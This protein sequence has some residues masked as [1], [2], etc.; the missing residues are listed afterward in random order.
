MSK[1]DQAYL[2]LNENSDIL[3]ITGYADRWSTRPGEPVTFHISTNRAEYRADIVELLGGMT[4]P[5]STDL[6]VREVGADCDGVHPGTVQHTDTGS[7]ATLP[8][9]EHWLAGGAFTVQLRFLPT[10][11]QAT[12]E[13]VLFH[14]GESGDGDG[15][16]HSVKLA[17]DTDGRLTL[18]L[19]GALGEVRLVSDVELRSGCWFFVSADHDGSTGRARLYVAQ[20]SGWQRRAQRDIAEASPAPD[21]T[22]VRAARTYL[23]AAPTL[24]D[25]R[26]YLDS[27]FNGKIENPRCYG[28]ALDLTEVEA[29]G[30]GGKVR[31]TSLVA[32]YDLGQDFSSGRLHDLSGNNLHGTLH[33]APQRGVTSSGW[34]GRHTDFHSAPAHYAA[35][36]FHEDDIEDS[37]WEPSLT[38]TV[39]AGTP[40]GA[41]ALRLRA[42]EE[43]DYVPFFVRRPENSR[44]KV[45]FLVPSFTYQAYAN[46]RL[47]ESGLQEDFMVHDMALAPQ[48]EFI[49]RHDEVGKS[50]YDTHTDGSGVAYSSRLRPVLNLRP[51]YH[52]WLS[53]H[54]RHLAADLFILGW[55][56]SLGEDYDF[57]IALDEDLHREGPALLARYDTLVTGSHP[58]YWTRDMMD[59]LTAY[60]GDGGRLMY[61]G[62]NGFYWV[63]S[64]FEDRPHLIE[65]RRGNSGTRC[66]DSPPGELVHSA[67]G[68]HGGL[69]RFNG[70]VP[71]QL[72]GVGM[73]A[74]GWGEAAGYR[75][76]DDSHDE[77][78]AFIFDGIA[79]DEVIGDFGYVLG[80]AAGDEVDRFG[81]DL[82]TPSNALRLATSTGLDDRYQI[83]QEELLMTAPGQGGTE[84]ELVRSDLTYFE[85][86]G[87]GAVFSTGS[88]CWAGSLAW[89]GFDNNVARITRNVLAKFTQNE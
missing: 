60:L 69:W 87:G 51:H 84:N 80:G 75:R 56:R 22:G 18:T 78:V 19:R 5:R 58:E 74:Q 65:V 48:D 9:P 36:H 81:F 89:N 46:E 17:I 2:R 13:Q 67:S 59:S 47:F 71:Q 43:V 45:L 83:T 25:G 38:W 16:G 85:I 41:Y 54:V 14:S 24:I 66:W 28:R 53:G 23:A 82:G 88:I 26:P 4:D 42:G 29:A 21:L 40:P 77:S 57:D 30:N 55:L 12:H 39:P 70:Y 1:P 7:Y 34:N 27:H 50:L 31:P 62:G 15:Q 86:D 8:L 3:N 35:V 49:V 44:A 11:P 37:G 61:L 72:V 10:M 63:T 6:P 68:D 73:A 79:A 76:L 33:Q 52:N 32:D 64:V 20:T